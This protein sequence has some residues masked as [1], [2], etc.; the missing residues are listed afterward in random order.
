MRVTEVALCI[1]IKIFNVQEVVVDGQVRLLDV[2][3]YL[4][5]QWKIKIDKVL[6]VPIKKMELS[7]NK[8]FYSGIRNKIIVRNFD[9]NNYNH[10]IVNINVTKTPEKKNSKYKYET[11]FNE[12]CI[13]KEVKITLEFSQV[14]SDYD[15]SIDCFVETMDSK[16]KQYCDLTIYDEQNRK[17][18][19]KDY[20]KYFNN[21]RMNSKRIIQYF[22]DYPKNYNH[23]GKV[24]DGN[25]KSQKFDDI[26]NNIN[27]NEL[28]SNFL[29]L[30]GGMWRK[31]FINKNSLFHPEEEVDILVIVLVL[32]K[33]IMN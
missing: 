10:E 29:K 25:K 16:D 7:V 26:F 11:D 33:N 13:N 17:I 28:D 30:N 6:I 31:Y 9:F 18:V 27:I 3:I 4:I 22:I 21:V 5:A 32:I 12:K 23:E 20:S 2:Q 14:M 19:L 15:F 24:S 1:K 8:S